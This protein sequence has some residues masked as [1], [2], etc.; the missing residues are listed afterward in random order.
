MAN[1]ATSLMAFAVGI[2]TMLLLGVRFIDKK[3]IGAYLVAGLVVVACAGFFFDVS[4]TLIG[5]LGRESTMTGRTEL[6]EDVLAFRTNPVLGAGFESFWLGGRTE[7]LWAKHWWRPNQAHN[8][9]LET[10]LNLGWVGVV[11]LAVCILSVF[12]KANSNLLSDFALGRFRMGLL[13]SVVVY[14]YT[15]AT[16][17]A[18]HLLYFAFYLIAIDYPRPRPAPVT[19]TRSLEKT[20]RGRALQRRQA[21]PKEPPA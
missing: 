10:Y 4:D 11:L 5:S 8:G 7:W 16:F 3:H 6:W 18:L 21:R 15:E 20:E 2:S 14:N 12:R 1:S 9:Y 13:A 19:T 17:K